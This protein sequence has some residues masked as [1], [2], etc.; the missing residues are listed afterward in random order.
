MR[1][2]ESCIARDR[3]YVVL[4]EAARRAYRRIPKDRYSFL[5]SEVYQ[6]KVDIFWT[7][8]NPTSVSGELLSSEGFENVE[9]EYIDHVVY[10]PEMSTADR[11]ASFLLLCDICTY[12]AE[13]DMHMESHMWNVVLQHGK[14]ILIDIGDFFEGISLQSVK[15]TILGTIYGKSDLGHT[16]HAPIHPKKWI[17]NYSTISTKLQGLDS[18]AEPLSYLHQLRACLEEIV[19]MQDS[20]VW[21][22]YPVQKNTPTDKAT[23]E[24]YAF[25]HRPAIC[26]VIKEKAPTTLVDV[27]CSYGLY[28]FFAAIQGATT[29]GFDCSQQMIATANEKSTHFNLNCNFSYIDILDIN[30]WGVEGCYKTCL[31]R[32]KSEA[33][34]VPAV[35]HHVHGKNKPLEQIITEWASMARKWIMLEYIPFDTSNRPISSELI[36]KTLSDLEFT[37]IKFIDSSPSPRYWILAEKVGT[38]TEFG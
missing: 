37:S 21:D 3:G 36:V 1:I 32:F 38:F 23:L 26:K 14:P 13:H 6:N 34:I 27:G 9:V 29:V 5:L 31:E 35:I 8:V 18:V 4:D 33:V 11:K 19:P 30:S 24:K 10:W 7:K 2:P 12:L 25:D 16:T 17:S 22:S 20:F 15:S 28:S